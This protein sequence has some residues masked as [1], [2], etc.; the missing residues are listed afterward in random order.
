MPF[1]LCNAAATFERVMDRVFQGLRWGRCLVYLD[2]IIS[3]GSTFDGALANLTLIFE[4]LRS[5]GLQL[6]STKCHLFRSSIPFLGHI[7]GRHGLECD[8][9]KI[10]DVKSW[11]VPV[12][13]A[14][15]NF[16]GLSDIT[17]DSFLGLQ[18][19]R[20]H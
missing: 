2:D 18:M 15:V 14:C 5:Y 19:W 8:P 10:E 13:R 16:W 9:A 7:V 20:H 11:P 4:R 12:L 3:F 1:G 17:D 6:M